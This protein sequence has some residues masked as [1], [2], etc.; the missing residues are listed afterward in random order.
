MRSKQVTENPKTFV[1]ILDTGD[2]ILSSRKN[3][4]E[5]EHP[6]SSSFKA[7]GALSSVELGRFD[8]IP[9]AIWHRQRPDG[10]ARLD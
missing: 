5:T 1:I 2:E 10:H 3:F 4:A 9:K 6:A 7:I 8:W